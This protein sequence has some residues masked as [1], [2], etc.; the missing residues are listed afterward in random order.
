MHI[1]SLKNWLACGGLHIPQLYLVGGTVRDLLLG[2]HPKDIDLA[3][4]GAKEFASA[5]A[6]CRDAALVPMEKKPQEPC[7]RVVD[8]KDSGNYLDIAEMRG[9]TIHDDLR[10]RDFTV[11]AMA[12]ELHADGSFGPL[13]DIVNGRADI[14]AMIIRMASDRSI[15]SDPLRILRAFR[16]AAQLGFSIDGLTLKEMKSRAGSLRDISSERIT[17]ELM[18]LFRTSRA[19]SSFRQMDG[20]GI[21]EVIFSEITAMKGCPQNG[22]HHLDVWEHSL[23]VVEQAEHIV[24]APAEHFGPLGERVAG[25]LGSSGRI[26]LLKFGALLHDVGKPSTKDTD[27]ASGRIT[28]YGHDEK[29]AKLTDMISQRLKLSG[30]DRDFISQLAREHIRVLNLISGNMKPAALM[31]WFRVMG[32]DSVSSIILGMAD[33]LSSR[34]PESTEEYRERFVSSGKMFVRDYFETIKAKIGTPALVT[35]NDLIVL[36]IGPGPEIGRVLE[37]IQSAQ[38]TGEVRNRDEALE[39]ARK[40]TGRS[41]T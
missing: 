14:E 21:P 10:Q 40:L 2:K 1:P 16:I 28:F 22:F 26:P 17:A 37:E 25:Y 19:G 12:F 31:K 41:T 24:H 35:G 36:G 39:L 7:Y 23:M 18:L 15:A 27:P 9:E 4:R 6:G 30:R 11:D 20:L 32:D 29:G 38:D 34:G 8:R 5:L 33:V 3:C 13:I